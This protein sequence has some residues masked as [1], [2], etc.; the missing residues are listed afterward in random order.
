VPPCLGQA[1]LQAAIRHEMK[2]FL[3]EGLVAQYA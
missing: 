2:R 1:Q 3:P